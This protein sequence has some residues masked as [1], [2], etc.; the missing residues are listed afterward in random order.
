MTA[1][2]W[3][4]TEW[5]LTLYRAAE[6]SI[7]TGVGII[8]LQHYG[9]S[10]SD[11]FSQIYKYAEA[12]LPERAGAV[13]LRD[14][15][16]APRDIIL[17]GQHVLFGSDE[18]AHDLWDTNIRV[19]SKM[20]GQ[21]SAD[22][23][24][25]LRIGLLDQTSTL[26]KYR[27]Y[28]EM[29]SHDVR[30]VQKSNLEM[31]EESTIRFRAT[32][33]HVYEDTVL[34]KTGAVVNGALV[35]AASTQGEFDTNRHIIKLTKDGADNPS[36][37]TVTMADGEVANFD[38]TLTVASEYWKMDAFHG[39][40]R[41]GTAFANETNVTVAQFSGDFVDVAFGAD[42]WTIADGGTADFAFEATW[43]PRL[44]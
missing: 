42:S 21:A 25:Y 31:C 23:N 3:S 19:I 13:P 11:P 24:V 38:G 27:I 12:I 16:A 5:S 18:D 26:I 44:A 36:N 30:Y 14:G 15:K 40:L 33:P 7:K 28:G 17:V 35:A 43:L 39:R 29:I 20:I 9:F 37:V 8:N 6:D 1:P 41:R 34:S 10:P 22:E 4:S 32:D 2:L